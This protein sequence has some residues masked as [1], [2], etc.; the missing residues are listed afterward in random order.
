M[1]LFNALTRF[2]FGVTMTYAGVI[3]LWEQLLY[4]LS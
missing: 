3:F 4:Y 1:E 2:A